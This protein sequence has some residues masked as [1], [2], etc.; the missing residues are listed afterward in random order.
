MP[1]TPLRVCCTVCAYNS[2]IVLCQE[3]QWKRTGRCSEERD[4]PTMGARSL[5]GS[6][7]T[8][9]WRVISTATITP[10]GGRRRY[11]PYETR[12][13]GNLIIS[14]MEKLFLPI[15]LCYLIPRGNEEPGTRM[16]LVLV[17]CDSAGAL[18]VLIENGKR[19]EELLSDLLQQT[20]I[21]TSCGESAKR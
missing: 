5:D 2:N 8:S 15:Q 17:F 12:R 7:R 18:L 4:R 19:W 14:V 1:S 20:A 6:G 16:S 11:L 3:R 21:N 10:R 13:E 9:F